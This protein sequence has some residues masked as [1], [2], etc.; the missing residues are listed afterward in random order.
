LPPFIGSDIVRRLPLSLACVWRA[1]SPGG[2]D[3]TM[4]DPAHMQRNLD[5]AL[6]PCRA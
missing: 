6:A 1:S 2:V 4:F 3:C 5:S